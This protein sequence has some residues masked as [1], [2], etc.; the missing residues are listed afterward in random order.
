MARGRQAELIINLDVYELL[1]RLNDGYRPSVEEI[2]GFYRTLVVFKNI[3]A[4]APYKE[5][6]LTE[7]GTEFYWLRRGDDGVLRLE[8]VRGGVNGNQ[9]T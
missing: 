6:M 3:L 5:V 7:S 4:S 9:A 8:P 1:M 2:E